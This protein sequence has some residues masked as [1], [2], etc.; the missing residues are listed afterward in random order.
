M[1]LWP[2]VD[3]HMHDHWYVYCLLMCFML[4]FA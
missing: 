3:N 4:L 2:K 1:K